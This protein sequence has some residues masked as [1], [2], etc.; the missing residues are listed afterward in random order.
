MG[1]QL[2]GIGNGICMKTLEVVLLTMKIQSPWNRKI[3]TLH[4]DSESNHD[5]HSDHEAKPTHT[6]TFKCIGSTY[7]SNAQEVLCKASKLLQNNKDMPTKLQ[8]EPTNQ[9]D[10]RAIAFMCYIDKKWQRV[11]YVVQECL[12]HVHKALLECRQLNYVGQSI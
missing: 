11:G 1:L 5:S 4:S 10:T 7:D 2:C 12:E 8:P 9:Y 6:L 3:L